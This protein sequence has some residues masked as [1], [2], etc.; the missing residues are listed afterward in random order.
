MTATPDARVPTRFG[1]VPAK[2]GRRLVP[3]RDHL[4]AVR[5]V[6]G[7]TFKALYSSAAEIVSLQRNPLAPM[8]P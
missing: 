2:C 6:A 5:F 3:G 8:H 4:R 1:A 7:A